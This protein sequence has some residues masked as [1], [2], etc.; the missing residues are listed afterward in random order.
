MT[1]SSYGFR[2]RRSAQEAILKAREYQR[3][4]K[5]WV[6]DRD[7]K[8]FFDEVD[9][10][11]LMT[12][13]GKKVK[14]KRL[15]RLVNSFFKAGVQC[16]NTNV[17]TLKGTPQGGPL[18]PSLSNILLD[19][20]DKELEQRGHIFCLYAD[21]CNIYIRSRRAGERVLQS[22]TKYVEDKL[23]LKVNHVKSAVGR[24]WKRIFLGFSFTNHHLTRI[25]VSKET[26][27][28]FRL[29]LKTLFRQGRGRNLHV[30]SVKT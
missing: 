27:R 12:R 7:L 17:S 5:R 26:Q 23:K 16:G 24:P 30:L 4:G 21:D 8:Q 10:D 20:L 22:V 11:I 14:D 19:D 29:H 15:K 13:L 25:R 1:E 2:P 9:H 6:V 18:S 28:S 3:S